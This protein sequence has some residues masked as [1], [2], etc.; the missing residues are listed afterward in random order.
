MISE[1]KKTALEA[2]DRH[3]ALLCEVSDTIWGYAELSLMEYQSAALYV[4]VLGELGFR[5][6]ENLA[7]MPTAFSGAFGHGRPV[8]G[9]LGEFDA[10]SGLSQK[11]CEAK[12]EPLSPGG[13]GHG[14]GH[15]MLGAGSLGAA[16]AVKKYLELTGK[17][18]TVIF[19]GCPGEEGGA[20]KAFMA[21]EG[22]WK[23]LDAAL[24]WHPDD[25]NQVTTGTCNSCIRRSI[26][27]S[28]S[29]PTRRATPTW[30]GPP[31][32]LWS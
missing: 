12:R 20:G 7:G 1:S 27:S 26:N 10:L 9:I 16:V 13:N 24:S 28:A 22:M 15:H 32:T 25:V 8:I 5:V 19:Y 11:G 23:S 14:C 17:E 30:E 6:R 3:G 29:P 18:G 21:R 2:V 31:W 4:K